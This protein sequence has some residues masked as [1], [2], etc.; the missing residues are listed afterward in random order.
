M[1]RT[2]RIV[3]EIAAWSLFV[4]PLAVLL[5]ARRLLGYGRGV[6]ADQR[7]DALLRWYPPAWR[8]RHGDA[9]AELLREADDGVLVRLDVAREGVYERVRA[10]RWDRV[11]AGLL[12][13]LGWTMFF[14]QGVVAAA[15][16][17]VDL[18]PSWFLALNV[19]GDEQWLVVGAMVGIGLL[20]ID[21]GMHVYAV[22]CERRRYRSS[23]G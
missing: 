15:L 22:D 18:P 9:L 23:A 7:I 5:T 21:R 1:S 20:L 10:V 8:E 16:T 11:R 6:T 13:G 17:Q 14:P 3:A 2:W 4:V 12:I 19:G